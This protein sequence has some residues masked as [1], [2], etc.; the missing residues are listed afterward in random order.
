MRPRGERGDMEALRDLMEARGFRVKGNRADCIFCDGGS[1]LTVSIRQET[2]YCHRCQ[3]SGGVNSLKRELGM[4]IT[5]ETQAERD[6]RQLEIRFESWREAAEFLIDDYQQKK[7]RLIPLVTLALNDFPDMGAAW[8][9]L[10]DFYDSE[11]TLL[12]ALEMLRFEKEPRYADEPM[13]RGK[14][15]EIFARLERCTY[16][17]NVGAA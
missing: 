13:T 10:R 8:E 14:L 7:S 2:Y 12:G 16:G 15:L 17:V 4:P 3:K 11:A 1:R 6:R 5:P 9:V